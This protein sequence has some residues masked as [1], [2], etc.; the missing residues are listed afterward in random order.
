MQLT[1]EEFCLFNVSAKI[2]LLSKDGKYIAKRW[3]D[4]Q[5]EILLYKMSNYFVEHFV[6][7]TTGQTLS[8]QPVINMQSL[9]WYKIDKTNFGY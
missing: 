4:N 3:L 9:A 1:K 7:I 2:K 6:N 8:V 5:H